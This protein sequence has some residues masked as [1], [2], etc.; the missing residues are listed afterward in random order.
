MNSVSTETNMAAEMTWCV[1][2]Y[3]II[4]DPSK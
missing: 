3:E 1:L 4:L 2:S